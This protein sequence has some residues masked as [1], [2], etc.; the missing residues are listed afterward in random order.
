M[1]LDKYDG[2]IL[3][4]PSSNLCKTMEYFIEVTSLLTKKNDLCHCV[5]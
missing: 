4:E 2:S 1:V 5:R 3:P